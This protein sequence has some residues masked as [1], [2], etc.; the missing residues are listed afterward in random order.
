MKERTKA[1][2]PHGTVLVVPRRPHPTPPYMTR[3]PLPAALPLAAGHSPPPSR[4]PPWTPPATPSAA[5]WMAVAD[6][7]RRR[8]MEEGAR[9]RARRARTRRAR[10]RRAP[11]EGVHGLERGGVHARG[12]EAGG[13]AAR[14]PDRA[15]AAR[16]PSW[17]HAPALRACPAA[18]WPRACPPS[19]PRPRHP[20]PLTTPLAHA[21]TPP[22]HG[23][24]LDPPGRRPPRHPPRNT[25]SL[26]R[27]SV[28]AASTAAMA[29]STLE[30]S[31]CD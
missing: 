15:M 27:C 7:G 22:R 1:L 10:A 21:A 16:P 20:P 12:G 23:L 25:I 14:L 9:E 19:C 13:R 8:R 4:A 3:R 6:G 5:R 28:L 29:F 18:P 24:L 17:P 26:P 31:R 2:S 30:P 11:R